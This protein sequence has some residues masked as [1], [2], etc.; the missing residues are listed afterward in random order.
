MTFSDLTVRH[1][2]PLIHTVG[3]TYGRGARCRG[4]MRLP[5]SRLVGRI[6]PIWRRACRVCALWPA[7]ALTRTP[8]CTRTRGHGSAPPTAAF[9]PAQCTRAAGRGACGGGSRAKRGH[10]SCTD[11]R[12]GMR[13]RNRRVAGVLAKVVFT[14]SLFF[15]PPSS[16]ILYMYKTR[17]I[18]GPTP[19]T[20]HYAARWTTPQMHG[21]AHSG[22]C[23]AQGRA[24]WPCSARTAPAALTCSTALPKDKLEHDDEDIADHQRNSQQESHSVKQVDDLFLH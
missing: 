2:R 23:P 16:T 20:S 12:W 11:L 5:R 22:G 15:N 6:E 9:A 4:A 10:S 1:A 8:G 14:I 3:R 17:I 18:V 7:C 13:H 21:A 24:A 19:P